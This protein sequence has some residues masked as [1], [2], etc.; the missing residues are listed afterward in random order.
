MIA[1]LAAH[2]RRGAARRRTRDREL[3][4]AGADGVRQVFVIG[5]RDRGAGDLALIVIDAAFG[6]VARAVPQL[7]VFSV[8]LPGEDHRRLRGRR[9]R[10]CRSSPTTFATSSRASVV[11]P[12]ADGGRVSRCRHRG[13]DREGD[14]QAPQRGAQ[15][16]PGR[17]FDGGQ[18]G[19]VLL[20]GL[21]V[22]A[23]HRRRRISRTSD[24]DAGQ[25]GHRPADAQPSRP[26]C[27][28][29]ATSWAILVES[30]IVAPIAPPS[31]SRAHRERAPGAAP[32]TRGRPQAARS[33]GS[34]R[35]PASSAVRPA[36]AV[37]G[38]QGDRQDGVIGVVAFWSRFWPQ[39]ADDGRLVG[40]PPGLAADDAGHDLRCSARV[41]RVL[42]LAPDRGARLRLAAQPASRS[43]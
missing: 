2:L 12:L 21:G 11:T 15:E 7:N 22:I 39:H 20:A 4:A 33:G 1:G 17:R 18:L 28:G 35:S 32:V 6:L 42:A 29:R 34:T 19:V 8:G 5:A 27:D 3:A 14:T 40:M 43:R 9:R 23:R 36:V 31:R 16:R 24:V 30:A 26:S 13:Q 37:R 25:P 10:R 38:G 41:R